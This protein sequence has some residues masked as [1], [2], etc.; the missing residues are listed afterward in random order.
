M[1]IYLIAGSN[2]IAAGIVEHVGATQKQIADCGT[3]A[4]V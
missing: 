4:E 3:T 1:R 2:S